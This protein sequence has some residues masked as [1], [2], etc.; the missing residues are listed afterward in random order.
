MDNKLHILFLCG[1]YPSRVLTNNGDFVQRHAEAVSTLHK[2]SALHIISDVNCVKN[3]EHTFEIKNDVYTYITYIKPTKNPFLKGIRFYK[4]FKEIFKKIGAFDIVHLHEI[5]PFGIFTFLIKKPLLISEHWT[6]YH[7][8]QAKKI[9]PIQIFF[10]RLIVKK[11]LFICPVSRELQSAMEKLNF[12]GDYAIVPNVVDTNKFHPPVTKNN[13][14]FTILHIS[15]MVD[16]H[17]N[18]SGIIRAVAKLNFDYKLILIGENASKYKAISDTLAISK[19]IDFIDHLPHHKMPSFLQQANVY[20]S[21]SNYETWGIVMMEA[22]A[23][24][25][26][27]ISTNTGIINELKLTDFAEIIS[28]KNEAALTNAIEKTKN[29]TVVDKNKMYTYVNTNFSPAK[30]AKQ[31]SELYQKA[32]N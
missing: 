5:F 1:W 8:P 4:A 9:S 27:V 24:G 32:F 2:V 20:V 6:G 25:T 3:I 26:P 14:V 12:K 13:S 31:F 15:N 29:E 17:K 21:F 7:H 19:N 16:A 28:T 11:A 10:T 30:I 23:C 22:L 18:V